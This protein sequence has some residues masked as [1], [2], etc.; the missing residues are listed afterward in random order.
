MTSIRALFLVL[1]ATAVLAWPQVSNAQDT[2]NASAPAAQAPEDDPD[3]DLNLAQP[4]FSLVNLRTTLRLPKFRSAFR[5]THRFGRALGQGDFGDLAEDF[6]GLDNGGLIGLEFRFGLMPGLQVGVLRTSDRT[7]NLFTQYSL[8]NQKSGSPVGIDAVATIDGT[9]NFKD[10]YSPSLGA[11]ISREL[12]EWGALY[13]QPMWV[14]NS[15]PLPGELAESNDTFFFGIG[16]RVRVRPTVYVVGEFAPRG[17][18]TP[19][20]HQ[21]SFGIE[22]RAGGHTFQLNFSDSL[23]NTP[24]QLA[25][26]GGSSDDWYIGFNISRKFF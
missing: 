14:N 15:N 7:I 10:S 24:R 3:R 21:A 5:V 23:G 17:G 4:D 12:G 25:Q 8:M 22:K 20:A 2:A 1:V 19:G 13:A 26:G 9:N 11:V 16:A 6:F 18:F